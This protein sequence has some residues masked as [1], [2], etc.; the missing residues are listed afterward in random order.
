ML[1]H[2]L[3]VHHTCPSIKVMSNIVGNSRLSFA[4][5]QQVYKPLLPLTQ[6]YNTLYIYP[7]YSQGE[8][9]R[10]H[11][12]SIYMIPSA[13]LALNNCLTQWTLYNSV[14]LA[15]LV[16]GS[17]FLRFN[18]RNTLSILIHCIQTD[19][20]LRYIYLTLP[21]SGYNFVLN[22]AHEV[23][24]PE[25]EQL[26]KNYHPLKQKYPNLKITSDLM[27]FLLENARVSEKEDG[28]K[29]HRKFNQIENR[30]VRFKI[31]SQMIKF[32]IMINPQEQAQFLRDKD[33]LTQKEM[34]K[35][36]EKENVEV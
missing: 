33:R 4:C 1:R 3:P 32:K 31:P 8:T 28:S 27:D 9:L 7:V 24:Y 26:Q 12:I 34:I 5:S 2:I 21:A 17:L 15:A 22:A 30:L 35:K 6:N 10:P 13:L 23:H 18:I 19:P 16:L 29:L 36:Y 11:P 25:K 14:G 20:Q